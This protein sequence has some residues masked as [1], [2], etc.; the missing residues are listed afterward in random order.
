MNTQSHTTFSEMLVVDPI[1]LR[2][3]WWDNND[4]LFL[5]SIDMLW[6]EALEHDAGKGEY[7]ASEN[8]SAYGKQIKIGLER[9]VTGDFLDW[10]AVCADIPLSWH[11]MPPFRKRVL[12]T[13]YEHVGHGQTV[14]YGQLAALAGSPKAARAVGSAMSANPW[15]LIVP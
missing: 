1:I 7:K 4:E 15:P 8:I 9:Y 5:Q 14:T 3:H 6:T 11:A 13:L 10:H 12:Q 2:L